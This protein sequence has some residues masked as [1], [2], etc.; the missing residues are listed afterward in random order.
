MALKYYKIN[1]KNKRDA[2]QQA[3]NFLKKGGVIILPTETVYGLAAD[4][5]NKKA[6]RKIFTLKK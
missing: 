6:V 3:V 5:F 4:P 1:G 2:I